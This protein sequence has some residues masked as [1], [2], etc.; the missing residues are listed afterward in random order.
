MRKMLKVWALSVIFFNRMG[1]NH[2]AKPVLEDKDESWKVEILARDVE[3][4]CVSG[5]ESADP[6]L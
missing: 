3:V 5:T 2:T 1:I 6:Y 4:R